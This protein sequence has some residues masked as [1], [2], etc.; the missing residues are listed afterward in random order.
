MSSKAQLGT[1]TLACAMSEVDDDDFQN[2]SEAFSV[3]QSRIL[4]SLNDPC[5]RALKP[6]DAS[7]PGKRP[8]KAVAAAA[9]GKENP[10]GLQVAAPFFSTLTKDEERLKVGKRDCSS[11]GSSFISSSDSCIPPVVSWTVMQFDC[12]NELQNEEY[13]LFQ[14]ADSKAEDG[15]DGYGGFRNF[16]AAYSSRSIESRLLAANEKSVAN[17]SVGGHL[18]EDD[19]EVLEVGTQLNELINICCGMDEGG[20]SHGGAFERNEVFCETTVSEQFTSV[21]CPLCG[22]DITDL[23]N[24]Q[25]EIHTNDC[26]DK[27][28]TMEVQ[29]I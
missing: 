23:S 24:E 5:L 16:K 17:I 27:A 7:R 20:S 13:S 8:R 12:R 26:L 9:E 22:G 19:C 6:A 14:S 4:S 11:T 29:V 15:K 25:R 18:V 10:Q 1:L 3:A 28:G 2:P 21:E